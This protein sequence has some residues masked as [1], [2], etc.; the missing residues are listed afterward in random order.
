MGV[1]GAHVCTLCLWIVF[2]ESLV[3]LYF[4]SFYVVIL[5]R[6]ALVISSC[7]WRCWV[8]CVGIVYLYSSMIIGLCP[9]TFI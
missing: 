6:I 3:R 5:G 4:G 2:G 1:G 8:C 7:V 9:F